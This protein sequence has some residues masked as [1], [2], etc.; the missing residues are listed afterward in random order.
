MTNNNRDQF[1]YYLKE[2]DGFF[3]IKQAEEVGYCRQSQSY[4]VAQGNWEKIHK[5]IYRIPYYKESENASLIIAS[6]WSVDRDS[7]KAGIISHESAISLHGVSDILPYKVHLTVPKLYGRRAIMSGVKLHRADLT[8][9]DVEPYDSFSVTTP[10]RTLVDLIKAKSL[11][12][13][14]FE[15]II[16][17]GLEKG[18]F[19][20][21]IF[22]DIPGWQKDVIMKDFIK[23]TKNY[24]DNIEL[25]D[26]LEALLSYNDMSPR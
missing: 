2:Q 23:I 25:S 14:L 6:L 3:T 7:G 11:S 19:Y 18:Y 9:Q 5:G 17:Q 13:D 8:D 16:F 22:L 12:V 24:P 26:C 15:Q 20:Y 4:H 10:V 21:D 1:H